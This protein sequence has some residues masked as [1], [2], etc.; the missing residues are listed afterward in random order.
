[1]KKKSYVRFSKAIIFQAI[2]IKF[3]IQS[4]SIHATTEHY[5]ILSM[6]ELREREREKEI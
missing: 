2:D 1:M 3:K 6:I 5:V 4:R